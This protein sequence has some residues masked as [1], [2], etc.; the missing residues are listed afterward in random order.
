VSWYEIMH[1]D[2]G[3][4]YISVRDAEMLERRDVG[5]QHHGNAMDHVSSRLKS[6]SSCVHK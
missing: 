5:T 6:C 3:V 1:S 2:S 4:G